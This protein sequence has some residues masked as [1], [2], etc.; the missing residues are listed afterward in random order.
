VGPSRPRLAGPRGAAL[1]SLALGRSVWL[2]G[3]HPEVAADVRG[4]IIAV[5]AEAGPAAGSGAEVIELSGAAL[6]GLADAHIHLEGLAEQQTWLN[7][8]SAPSLAT[9]L[10]EVASRSALLPAGAWVLGCAWDP[11]RWPLKPA[12]SRWDLDR[13]AGGRPVAIF[14]RDGHSAWLSSSALARSGLADLGE[15]PQGA[16]LER[17]ERG[18][19]T[20]IIR[21]AALAAVQAAIPVAGQADLDRST[22]AALER[23]AGL[24]L[25]SLHVMDSSRGFLTLQRLQEQGR[26]R[27]RVSWFAPAALAPE[28]LR[29]GVR[30]GWGSQMLRLWGVKAFLDGTLSGGTAQML[31]G[32]GLAGL[33]QSELIALSR[34]LARAELNLA[35][36]A[37]GDGAVRRALDAWQPLAGAWARWRPRIEH[38][39]LV[40]PDDRGRLAAL[41]AIASMQPL[42]AVDD[43]ELARR[44]WSGRGADAYA[45]AA[46]EGAGAHLAFG[47]DAPVASPDP[48]LGVAAATKWRQQVGWHPE[49]ALTRSSALRAYSAGAA[50]AVGM[51]DDLGELSPGR[52]CDVTVVERGAVTA[53]VVGGRLIR[54]L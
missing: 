15:D 9:A 13:V 1:N 29:L 41:G 7:L 6:P 28:L 14:G 36:H 21:E 11:N 27:L 53:T 47:S 45:W 43:L 23:L 5:G 25:T 3:C 2:R 44:R 20:G 40:H 12:W 51:E 19:P 34:D 30:S 50:Y 52:L 22:L 24:G 46:L 16:V 31:T 32:G 18:E 37:I 38:A 49:L 8:G 48:L 26:L 10:T 54:G 17:D 4:R 35:V 33:D 39:Q 42:H